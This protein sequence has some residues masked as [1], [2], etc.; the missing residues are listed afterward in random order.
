M[1]SCNAWMQVAAVF[2]NAKPLHEMMLML[3]QQWSQCTTSS[4]QKPQ[5]LSSHTHTCL[6]CLLHFFEVK[7]QERKL[8]KGPQTT[9]YPK[10][11]L[12]LQKRTEMLRVHLTRWRLVNQDTGFLRGTCLSDLLQT[13][14]F[15]LASLAIIAQWDY[16]GE[17]YWKSTD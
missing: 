15:P 10:L 4:V 8:T 13:V 6:V 11:L 12:S 16:K 7:V 3:H 17:P 5:A 2:V 1:S 14:I 9:F